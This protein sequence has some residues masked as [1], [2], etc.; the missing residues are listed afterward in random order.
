MFIVSIPKAQFG[1]LKDREVFFKFS[2][3]VQSALIDIKRYAAFLFLLLVIFFFLV[4]LMAMMT[5]TAGQ[6]IS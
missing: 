1:F 2:V 5:V 4:I 6:A 3:K